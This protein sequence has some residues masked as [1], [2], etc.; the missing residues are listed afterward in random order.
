[1]ARFQTAISQ[2]SSAIY[3]QVSEQA[4]S[5]ARHLFFL[6]IRLVART[7]FVAPLVSSNIPVIRQS[8]S[9]YMPEAS[10]IAVS[11]VP[12]AVVPAGS[13]GSVL[14]G[15]EIRHRGGL[16]PNVL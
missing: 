13:L 14:G 15:G 12:V 9:R 10:V 7:C 8:S 5:V 2:L 6:A 16:R 11:V 3:H 4:T 1:M